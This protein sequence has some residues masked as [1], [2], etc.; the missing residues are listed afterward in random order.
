MK[1]EI[2]NFKPILKEYEF[3]ILQSFLKVG[4]GPKHGQ[5]N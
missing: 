2:L 5:I 1:K 4:S 3:K